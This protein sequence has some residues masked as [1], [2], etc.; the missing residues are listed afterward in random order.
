M[1]EKT[2]AETVSIADHEKAV[3]DAA[4][5]AINIY[6]K[7]VAEAEAEAPERIMDAGEEVWSIPGERKDRSLIIAF[8]A[9]EIGVDFAEVKCT[10]RHMRIARDSIQEVAAELAAS[11]VAAPDEYANDPIAYTWPDEGWTYEDCEADA[12]GAIAMYRCEVK[13]PTR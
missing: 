5:K 8:Y 1:A 12:P 10:R 4:W 11:V 7:S 2:E 9:S 3:E 13:E 6:V